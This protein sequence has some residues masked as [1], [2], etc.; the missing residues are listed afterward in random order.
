MNLKPQEAGRIGVPK[1]ALIYLVG[2]L[3]RNKN[4]CIKKSR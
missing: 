1:T 3:S 4:I 2:G